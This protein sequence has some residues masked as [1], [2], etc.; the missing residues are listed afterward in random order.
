MRLRFDD[1]SMTPKTSVTAPIHRATEGGEAKE[2]HE[3]RNRI[4][5]QSVSQTE[6]AVFEMEVRGR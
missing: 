2:S 1:H 4:D 3:A 6:G 5:G